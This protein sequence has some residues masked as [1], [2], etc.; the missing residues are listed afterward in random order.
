MVA[1]TITIAL[2]GDV[3]LDLF[4]ETL[5]HFNALVESLSAEVSREAD[6]EWSVVD[7]HAGGTA[8]TVSGDSTRPEAV[9]RV[10]R[11]Y[12]TVGRALQRREPVPYSERT[13]R[14]A[15][16]ITGII[17]GQVTAIRFE[18]AD[19]D[20]LIAQS[21]TEQPPTLVSAYGSVEGWVHAPADSKDR[22]F[23]L[24]DTLRDRAVSCYLEEGQEQLLRGAWGD[25][26]IVSGWVS[27]DAR[28]GRPIVIRRIS[29]VTPLP[30]V[31]PGSYR[32]ARGIVPPTPD[33]PRAEEAVRIIR[34]A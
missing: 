3:P 33:A 23:V 10:V 16:A 19:E 11:A 4:V 31:L 17:N 9:E 24:Y 30:E 28:T 13:A 21:G 29:R 1:R 25:R 32:Q 26:V 2:E 18:T 5:Q 7:T 12:A 14:H 15:R 20:V 34:D 27:R 6:I 8:A 22:R